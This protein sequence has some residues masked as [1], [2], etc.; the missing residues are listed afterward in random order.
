VTTCERETEGCRKPHGETGATR[1]RTRRPRVLLLGGQDAP[2]AEQLEG[3]WRAHVRDHWPAHDVRVVVWPRHAAPPPARKAQ[4][5][6]EAHGCERPWFD[7]LAARWACACIERMELRMRV[8]TQGEPEDCLSRAIYHFTRFSVDALYNREALGDRLVGATLAALRAEPIDVIVAHSFGGTIALRAAWE[9][10]SSSE[11]AR[12]FSLITLGSSSGPMVVN[13][14]MLE[15][16][17]RRDARICR[18]RTLRSWQH[19]FSESDALVAAPA[20]PR[21]FAGVQLVRVET[22][23]FLC[24]SR[25][26]ALSRYLAAPEVEAAICLQLM[27]ASQRGH[28]GTVATAE[29]ALASA[30]M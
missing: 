6:R 15:R 4:A 7:V 8:S 14:P 28:V 11:V 27:A 23:R 20:L 16:L 29:T 10:A 26:H 17:P 19:F 25:G 1:P 13:S 2:T 18:P 30:L 12:D 24:R 9:L 22:G 3:R 21:A 5:R